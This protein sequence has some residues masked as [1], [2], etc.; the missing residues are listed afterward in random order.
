VLEICFV[1][2]KVESFETRCDRLLESGDE[3]KV[4]H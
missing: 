2:G 1:S 4:V 3:V